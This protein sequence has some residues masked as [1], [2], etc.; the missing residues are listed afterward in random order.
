MAAKKYKQLTLTLLSLEHN[1]PDWY[2]DFDEATFRDYCQMLIADMRKMGVALEIVRNTESVITVNSYVDLLNAIKIS[3]VE[4]GHS[5]RCVGHVI[6]M[7][8]HLDIRE[9]IAA[10]VRRIAF[11]PETVVPSNEFKKVCHNCGCGC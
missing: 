9:D 6:G 8:P 10:A 4:G 7:S 5:N 11:A 1:R 2:V 3:S